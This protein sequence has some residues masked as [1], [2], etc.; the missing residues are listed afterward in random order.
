MVKGLWLGF[1]EAGEDNGELKLELCSGA[2]LTELWV[3]VV[4]VVVFV[5]GR[6][7]GVVLPIVVVSSGDMDVGAVDVTGTCVNGVGVPVGFVVE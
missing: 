2:V 1:R 3:C 6:V 7:G 4:P 5:S